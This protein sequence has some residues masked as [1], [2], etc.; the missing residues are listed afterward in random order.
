MTH[1]GYQ[2]PP[3][4]WPGT[5]LS[6]FRLLT[7]LV[8]M[9]AL[10]RAGTRVCEPVLDVRLEIPADVLG[11][12]LSTLVDLDARPGTPVV[13][14]RHT[15]L[16]AVIAA[17]R[18]HDLQTRL[19]DLTRGEGVLEAAFGGHRP[20]PGNPPTRPRTDLNPLDRADYLRRLKG[21]ALT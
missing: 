11:S 1:S 9:T 18:L 12:V 13:G 7:P 2:A 5:T 17:A 14:D 21:V 3:R 4:K 6:D 10:R 20:V 8:L 15:T 19:P 16:A